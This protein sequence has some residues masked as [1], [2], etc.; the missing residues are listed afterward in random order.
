M[1]WFKRAVTVREKGD[2]H[3]RVDGTSL[4]KSL[5]WVGDCYARLEDFV[6]ALHWFKLAVS[7][8][9]KGDVY[10]RVDATTLGGSLRRVG[11]IATRLE[12]FAEAQSSFEHA[13]AAVKGKGDGRLPRTNVG[14]S[15]LTVRT[16]LKRIERLLLDTGLG[17][18][19][20]TMGFS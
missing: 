16:V 19:R 11:E 8:A 15:L 20:C 4:G 17:T 14:M 13:A 3:G 1:R 12:R 2:A 5:H 18:S 7:A 10:E 6:E 9:K